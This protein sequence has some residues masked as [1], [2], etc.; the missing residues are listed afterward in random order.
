MGPAVGVS[1]GEEL[2]DGA[3]EGAELVVRLNEKDGL[4]EGHWSGQPGT[5]E[6]GTRFLRTPPQSSV[7]EQTPLGMAPVSLLPS[8]QTYKLKGE[9][10]KE[11]GMRKMRLNS[12]SKHQRHTL[13][14]HFMI[15]L[16]NESLR[17]DISSPNSDGIDPV[18]LLLSGPKKKQKG[19]T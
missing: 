16:L 3:D 4:M 5:F 7:L 19:E 8:G 17:S 12:M 18:S 1:E 6:F 13:W 14:F 15:Y 2:V 9:I 11:E 10:S